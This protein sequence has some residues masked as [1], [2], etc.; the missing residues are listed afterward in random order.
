MGS[1]ATSSWQEWSFGHLPNICSFVKPLPIALCCILTFIPSHSAMT[2]LENKPRDCIYEQTPHIHWYLTSFFQSLH[3]NET[4]S[5]FKWPAAWYSLCL[6][7]P[8]VGWSGLFDVVQSIV[9]TAVENKS[10]TGSPMSGPSLLLY[11][12][13]HYNTHIPHKPAL[14]LS[15]RGMLLT[16]KPQLERTKMSVLL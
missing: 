12:T 9:L 8:S 14:N 13:Q 1:L 5:L 10:R 15:N 16:W 11:Q 3:M 4:A 2:M 6:W 7:A